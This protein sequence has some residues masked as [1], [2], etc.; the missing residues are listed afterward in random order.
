MIFISAVGNPAVRDS[1][2]GRVIF[3]SAVGDPAVGNPAVGNP[4]VGDSRRDSGGGLNF[5]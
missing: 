2:G 5:D 3:I 4:A 1:G